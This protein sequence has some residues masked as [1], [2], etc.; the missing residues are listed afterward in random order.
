[1]SY[2][3]VLVR[4]WGKIGYDDIDFVAITAPVFP[5][6]IAYVTG[7]MFYAFHAPE[8]I[9]P[10]KFDYIGAS[11]QVSGSIVGT[12]FCFSRADE[13]SAV[14]PDLAYLDPVR[15]LSALRGY[16]T[17]FRWTT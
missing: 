17:D 1:M 2:H 6:V 14:F 16:I 7:L 4:T 11:H 15:D 5:S 12:F 13:D 8:S 9:W 10:G 3:F